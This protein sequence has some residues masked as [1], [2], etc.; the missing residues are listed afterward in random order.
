MNAAFWDKLQKVDRRVLY[1]VLVVLTSIGLF[2]K[3]EIPVA[4]DDS[5]ADFYAKLMKI[6]PNKPVVVQTDWT[7]ST[8]GENMAHLECLLRILMT[9]K[10][11]FVYYSATSDAPAFQVATDV[12]R[13]INEERKA[14]NL[15]VYERG[16]DYIGLG[17]F[18][19]AEGANESMR[20][21]IKKAWG[22][23][24]VRMPDGNET[25]IFQTPVLKGVNSMGDFGLM[26]VVTASDTIDFAV[27]RLNDKVELTGMATGVIAPGMLPYYQARQLKGFA[28]GLKG[29]YDMEYMMKHGINHPEEG[30]KIYVNAGKIVGEVPPLGSGKDLARA[31]QYYADLHIA[32]SLLIFA[33]V[34]GNVAMFAQKKAKK[35][36][37]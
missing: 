7:I 23:R 22:G 1:V 3:A 9:R 18:P 5:S 28:G 4:V 15:K 36:A 8:R 27:Q 37:E 33:V 17:L 6:D 13:H 16:T 24:R 10:I 20:N 19:N 35:G 32:L 31:T 11:K 29:C 2:L 25:D 14:M 30:G 12:I 34:V 26:V 21:D